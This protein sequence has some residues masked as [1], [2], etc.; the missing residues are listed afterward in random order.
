MAYQAAQAQDGTWYA[1]S[2]D[3]TLVGPFP[4]RGVLNEWILTSAAQMALGEQQEAAQLR[5]KLMSD[6]ELARA[7]SEA[8][9]QPP[10]APRGRG[11]PD[12]SLEADIAFEYYW[13]IRH[14]W[15]PAHAVAGIARERGCTLDHVRQVRSEYAPVA[16]YDDRLLEHLRAEAHQRCSG[17]APLVA[18][19]T[20]ETNPESPQEWLRALLG[21]GPM[22]AREVF[23]RGEMAGFSK[24]TLERAKQALRVVSAPGGRNSSWKLPD[25]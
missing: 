14:G 10:K 25:P 22:L 5:E 19:S 12:N 3:G 1:V 18:C 7:L 4:N 23:Q 17:K 2:P 15:R 13:R 11:V 8:I 24:R 9:R 16:S 6:E 20:N 21:S